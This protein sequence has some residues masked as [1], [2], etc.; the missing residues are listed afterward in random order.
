[1]NKTKTQAKVENSIII[2]TFKAGNIVLKFFYC[3]PN[4]RKN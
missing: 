4:S 3:I 2:Y 1:M